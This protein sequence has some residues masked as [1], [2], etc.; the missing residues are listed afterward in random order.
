MYPPPY[1]RLAGA[2]KDKDDDDVPVSLETNPPADAKWLCYRR[3]NRLTQDQTKRLEE[4]LQSSVEDICDEVFE[5]HQWRCFM[6]RVVREYKY[7]HSV[8]KKN[9][10]MHLHRET[11]LKSAIASVLQQLKPRVIRPLDG[12]VPNILAAVQP[13]VE[14]TLQLPGPPGPARVGTAAWLQN[15]I[16]EDNY[17][18]M[19]CHEYKVLM[20]D[21]VQKKIQTCVTAG[22]STGFPLLHKGAVVPGPEKLYEL[23][24]TGEGRRRRATVS[25]YT[26][27]N[28][29]TTLHTAT[30]VQ[31]QQNN[32]TQQRWYSHNRTTTHNSA[33][34]VTTEQR[35]TT[36][37]VQSQQNNDT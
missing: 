29:A 28:Q 10:R 11:V 6:D 31:S 13:M 3:R 16:K 30:L 22:S 2:Q 25:R 18:L 32:D 20:D 8:H 26:Q 7:L 27:N 21:R 23:C 36:A 34:T 12:D 9:D 15:K 14:I 24:C 1:L 33:G 5:L 37:L 4:L 17:F 19:E 35:H